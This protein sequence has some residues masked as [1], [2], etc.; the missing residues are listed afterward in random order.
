MFLPWDNLIICKKG[1]HHCYSGFA[2]SVAQYLITKRYQIS[3]ISPFEC[4]SFV[5]ITF[6][7]AIINNITKSLYGFINGYY[8]VFKG[9]EW[10][11]FKRFVI[12]IKGITWSKMDPRQPMRIQMGPIRYMGWEWKCLKVC[13]FC[14][15]AISS[16]FLIS[17]IINFIWKWFSQIRHGLW[18]LFRII[19]C[20]KKNILIVNF[21]FILG[22]HFLAY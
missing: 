17:R 13:T 22:S 3:F 19:F 11:V 1:G 4:A 14:K 10:R 21:E 5:Q 7:N 16:L 2:D 18:L 12:G 20:M 6:F 8:G 9:D 15:M